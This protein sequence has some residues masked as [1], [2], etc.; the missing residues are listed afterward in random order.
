MK[1]IL[2]SAFAAGCFGAQTG[3]AAEAAGPAA[4]VFATVNDTVITSAE[5]ESALGS[6]RQ[7]QFYHRQVPEGQAASF[8]RETAERL[9]NRVL[10][11]EE[12]A[13][14]GIQPDRAKVQKLVAGYDER[15]RGRP[16]WQNNRDKMLPALTRQLEQAD[17]LERL[18]SA[19]R[20]V[21][22]ADDAQLRGYYLAHQDLFT[23]P[24][25]VRLSVILLR[26][27]PSSPKVTWEKAR[28]EAA[29]IRKKIAAGS[30]F[31]ALAR[32]HS[33]DQSAERGGDMG[34]LHQ[35]ML[36]EGLY[37]AL[38]SMKPGDLSAPLTSLEGVGIFRLEDRKSSQLRKFEE[39]KQRAGQLL[40]REQG[41][42]RWIDLI[43][44]LRHN[45]S[46]RINVTRYPELAGGISSTR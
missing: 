12:G 10:L 15:Y 46:I 21:P 11:L 5:Y 44:T 22:E 28:E 23:E 42:Q 43:Q 34:Y 24:E 18:E 37:T 2:V 40:R 27:D 19:V 25:Q 31:A 7:Q 6:A 26:V 30:D 45:A 13:R 14:R 38:G 1:K 41:E 3:L 33:T 8:Q 29:A 35:G 16:Q 4:Q 9:I 32:L 17:V 20:T 36:P 39:V